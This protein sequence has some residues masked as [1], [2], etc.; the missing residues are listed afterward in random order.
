MVAL[1]LK[2][3]IV[4]FACKSDQKTNFTN[5]KGLEMTLTLKKSIVTKGWLSIV[6]SVLSV[7]CTGASRLV[8]PCIPSD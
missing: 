2:K 3:S 6:R 1:T 8:C 4:K 7:C 5:K